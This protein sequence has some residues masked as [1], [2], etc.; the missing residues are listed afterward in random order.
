MLTTPDDTGEDL[1]MK[2]LV[3]VYLEHDQIEKLSNDRLESNHVLLARRCISRMDEAYSFIRSNSA[4]AGNTSDRMDIDEPEKSLF[5]QRAFS[6]II[7]FLMM[8]RNFIRQRPE[9]YCRSPSPATDLDTSEDKDIL[10]EPLTIPYQVHYLTKGAGSACSLQIGDLQ[11]RKDLHQRISKLSGLAKFKLIWWGRFVDLLDNPMQTLRDYE[12]SKKGQILVREDASDPM[13]NIQNASSQA[14]TMLE[15][16]LVSEF[17][18]LYKF[19][20]AEDR[21]SSCTYDL[22]KMFE[23]HKSICLLVAAESTNPSEIFPDRQIYR[24]YYSLRCLEGLLKQTSRDENGKQFALHGLKL[25]EWLL[26][27]RPIPE[28]P[29]A[30]PNYLFIFQTAIPM[31]SKCLK[32]LTGSESSLFSD[33][34]QVVDRIRQVLQ[35][36]SLSPTNIQVAG[37][38]YEL[39]ISVV[40]A[41]PDSWA[42][43]RDSFELQ[44]LHTSLLL[45]NPNPVIRQTIV[46]MVK[47]KMDQFP[48]G[49]QTSLSEFTNYYWEIVSALIATSVE[50]SPFCQSLFVLAVEAFR[51]RF[52]CKSELDESEVAL[53]NNCFLK[54]TELLLTYEKN[55]VV[56]REDENHVIHGLSNLLS[57]C[58][59]LLKGRAEELS[60]TPLA[61]SLWTTFLFPTILSDDQYY[62]Q[63]CEVPLLDT[64]TRA[65]VYRLLKTLTL[66]D[67]DDAYADVAVWTKTVARDTEDPGRWDVDRTRLLRSRSGYLGLRNLGNTCYMNS[68][69]TQLFMS[70]EFRKFIIS[71]PN[72]AASQPILRE[73]QVLFSNMQNSFGPWG[74][75]MQL[76]RHI[77][78]YNGDNINVAEQM[79]VDEFCNLLFEQLEDQLAAV[80]AQKRLGNFFGGTLVYQIK[81]KECDHVSERE[82]PYFNI[83]CVIQGKVNLA[84]SLQAF[85]E[86][87]VMQG[88]NKY[89]C[90]KC[91][92]K[93]VEAVQR[94]CLKE[95]P[96][97]MILHLKRFEFDIGLQRRSK[98]NDYFEFPQWIDMSPYTFKHLANPGEPVEEDIFDLVGVLVH[99]G[100][101]EHGHYISYIRTRPSSE[102]RGPTWLLFDDSEVTEF[103]PNDIPETCYG[104]ISEI[105][106]NVFHMQSSVKVYSAYLL[107]YQRRSTHRHNRQGGDPM[108]AAKAQVPDL[109]EQQINSDN[110]RAL[111]SYGLFGAAHQSFV[112]D[113]C[114]KLTTISHEDHEQDHHHDLIIDAVFQHI[115]RVSC[116]QKDQPDYAE[117]LETLRDVASECPFCA[118]L[119]VVWFAKHILEFRDMLV[120]TN[121]PKIRH[122]MQTFAIALLK[123][124]RGTALYGVNVDQDMIDDDVVQGRGT[125]FIMLEVLNQIGRNELHHIIRGFDEFFGIIYHISRFGKHECWVIICKDFMTLALEYLIMHHDSKLGRKYSRVLAM[126]EKRQIYYNNVGELL[127]QLLPHIDF[128]RAWSH[129]GTR[130]DLV[131]EDAQQLPISAA[132]R[133]MM[134][135]NDA[136][137]VTWM[138]RLFEKWESQREGKHFALAEIL[139]TVIKGEAS[140]GTDRG[141]TQI[142]KT[143]KDGIET[144]SPYYAE[145]YIRLAPVFCEH[146]PVLSFARTVIRAVNKVL[147]DNDAQSGSNVVEFYDRLAKMQNIHFPPPDEGTGSWYRDAVSHS[148]IYGP[149]LLAWDDNLVKYQCQALLRDV[150][151]G[152]PPMADPNAEE[153]ADIERIRTRHV[154]LLFNACFNKAKICLE[155]DYNKGFLQPI[156]SVM[157]ECTGYI[158]ALHE[159]GDNA[160][161]M[162]EALQDHAMLE[163][164]SSMSHLS[165]RSPRLTFGPRAKGAEA[166]FE[167]APP[168]REEELVQSGES[169]SGGLPVIEPADNSDAEV[170]SEEF[171]E[172]S[173]DDTALEGN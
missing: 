123:T 61:E 25:L 125:L 33:G 133:N 161:E 69:L 141:L 128:K 104:V 38:L 77:R 163:S 150:L 110:A 52:S 158:K 153:P 145:I 152:Y 119:M 22:L 75:T 50:Y 100:Q 159:L 68:L 67:G 9:L 53:L 36:F 148:H 71:Q 109:L 138:I 103:D 19:M 23:P 130:L 134:A 59:K 143:M 76:V 11:T 112:K 17:K 54:W 2:F 27:S 28:D 111:H 66:E 124:L 35:L 121:I 89:K 122:Q 43:F 131:D 14:K 81:S 32:Q 44:E 92:G 107:F 173:D 99:K 4:D 94:Q 64:K 118:H 140:L 164:Y 3:D 40:L 93:L 90:E 63:A 10:G 101:A 16:E 20:D 156:M 170:L 96:N 24:V 57:E 62:S 7:K 154:R 129:S 41:C 82:E 73:L 26:I 168:E 117:L 72:A 149:I 34:A 51:H 48:A 39:M 80:S 162:K 85:V 116:R 84:E 1:A 46:H 95:I 155:S 172:C 137:G 47:N 113:L 144:L 146:C 83:P 142:C 30:R 42:A 60:I 5:E 108:E 151:L 105:E 169:S 127:S 70:P 74:D 166:A 135:L 147:I 55:E 15:R 157:K 126:M 12:A 106:N 79:D 37:E 167:V 29:N 86:G 171:S 139:A 136:E 88:D 91:G 78:T 8:L 56:G 165:P 49:S 97:N 160:D 13:A 115:W 6:R 21:V 65:A 114:L 45:S 58:F 98:I 120:R 132:E 87:D 102:P 31:F 18:T